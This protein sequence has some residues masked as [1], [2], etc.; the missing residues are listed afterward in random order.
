MDNQ[1]PTGGTEHRVSWLLVQGA[2]ITEV[3]LQPVPCPPA[4]AGQWPMV[5]YCDLIEYVFQFCYENHDIGDA[6]GANEG[7]C[8]VLLLF[9]GQRDKIRIEGILRTFKVSFP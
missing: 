8:K 2:L 1:N 3:L 4:A 5:N 6:T 9:R 7:K